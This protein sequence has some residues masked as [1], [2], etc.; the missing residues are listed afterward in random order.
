MEEGCATFGSGSFLIRGTGAFLKLGSFG[1]GLGAEKKEE[2]DFASLTAVTIGLASFLT[3]GLDV[4]A[5]AETAT[6]LAGGSAFGGGS[7]SLRFLL[8]KSPNLHH[9]RYT[10]SK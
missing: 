3:M 8:F 9:R 7:L 1:L 6:F 2:S 10:L 5:I 4:D